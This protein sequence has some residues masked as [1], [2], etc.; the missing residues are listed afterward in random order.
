MPQDRLPELQAVIFATEFSPMMVFSQAHE[1]LTRMQGLIK[2]LAMAHADA[3]TSIDKKSDGINP[4]IQDF[5]QTAAS[6]RGLLQQIRGS[7]SSNDGSAR[8]RM[9]WCQYQAISQ[10]FGDLARD[11]NSEQMAYH[12]K[13][14]QR[15]HRQL[16]I[17]GHASTDDEV[18]K[19]LARNDLFI[20]AASQLK[21]DEARFVLDEMRN[22]QK[23]IENL[24]E[25]VRYITE[26]F[27]EVA[28]FVETQGKAVSRIAENVEDAVVFVD[29]GGD[30]L[31]KYGTNTSPAQLGDLPSC[32]QGSTSNC[33]ST[34]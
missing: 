20:G 10:R 2:K 25:S 18:E 9:R 17:M 3:F 22:R 30:E 29:D 5:R 26:L 6:V 1:D 15:I 4:I 11:F 27:T 23:D 14:K 24:E 21:I 31:V 8:G 13:C 12:D 32:R 34:R 7:V 28:V 33:F 19:M 16:K